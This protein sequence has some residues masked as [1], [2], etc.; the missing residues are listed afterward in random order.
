MARFDITQG[1]IWLGAVNAD[2]AAAAVIAGQKI[3]A[4]V[5]ERM[6][7]D[8]A[9]ALAATLLPEPVVVVRGRALVA[10]GYVQRSGT[11]WKSV[12]EG[13]LEVAA[14]SGKWT[15]FDKFGREQEFGEVDWPRFGTV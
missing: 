6:D 11:F 5:I 10:A 13:V 3:L 9:P 15:L 2:C 4:D 14:G 12:A 7:I 1:G 8:G